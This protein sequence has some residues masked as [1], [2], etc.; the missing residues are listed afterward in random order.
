MIICF[1]NNSILFLF[2]IFILIK[3][4]C[5]KENVL[6]WHYQDSHRLINYVLGQSDEEAS[7]IVHL[8]KEGKIQVLVCTEV[9]REGFHI[10]DCKLV[11]KYELTLNEIGE[12]QATGKICLIAYLELCHILVRNDT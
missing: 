11:V 8:F 5:Q 9:A 1:R 2:Y 6:C 7:Q 4:K 3:F 12:R 10:A